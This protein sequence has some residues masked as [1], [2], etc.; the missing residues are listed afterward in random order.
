[1]LLG[2]GFHMTTRL[3]AQIAGGFG[4]VAAASAALAPFVGR[5][6]DRGS[7]RRGVALACTLTIAS[8]AVLRLTGGHLWGLALGVVLLDIA[9]QSGHIANQT[10]IYQAFPQARSRANTAYMVSYFLGGG[11][12]S[13]LGGLGWSHFGWDGVCAAGALL[14]TAGLGVMAAGG[15]TKAAIE[16]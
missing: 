12:G 13:L 1:V 15:R 10:R 14:A 2:P 11:M 7:V 4:L 6:L 8:F 16:P 5:W 9:V 3:A